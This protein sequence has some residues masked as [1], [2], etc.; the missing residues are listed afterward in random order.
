MRRVLITGGAGFI[1]S[2]LALKLLEKNYQITVLD[3]LS[4]QIHGENYEESYTFNLIKDRVEV[5]KGDV[6]NSDDWNEA[7]KGVDVVVHLAA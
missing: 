2:R 3:N 6:I 4:P 5:V 1:G 7:L